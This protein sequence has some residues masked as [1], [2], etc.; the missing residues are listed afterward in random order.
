[1]VRNPFLCI[2]TPNV[3]R[4]TKACTFS[5]CQLPKAVRTCRFF[6]SF[7]LEMSL[8]P[9]WCTFFWTPTWGAFSFFTCKCDWRHNGVQSLISHLTTTCFRTATLASLLFDPPEPQIIEKTNESRLS[10]LFAHLH[11]LSPHSFFS[12]IFSLLVFSSLIFLWLFSSLTLLTF[13]FPSVHIVG[14]LTS[15]LPS[16]TDLT[17]KL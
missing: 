8:A 15:K 1:M 17:W 12:L 3:L 14:S 10:H 5:T 16:I 6:D 4:A 9:Q 2:L 13:A 7:D 11:L